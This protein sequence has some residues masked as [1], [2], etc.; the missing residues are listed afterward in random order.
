MAVFDPIEERLCLRVVYDGAAGAGKTT[1][2]RQ[3]AVLF[4]AQRRSQVISPA[5]IGDKTLF[6]DWLQ[7]SAGAVC[8][9]P[10]ICQVVSVPGQ[11]A[12]TARRRRLLAS[13]DVVVFVCDSRTAELERAR[14][15]LSVLDDLEGE[16]A[17]VLQANKQD[18]ADALAGGAVVAALGRPGAAV[19]E[20]IAT[21]GIGVID[22]FVSAVR[23]AARAIE[24]R[25]EKDGGLRLPVRRA[26]DER[27]LLHTLAAVPIDRY[28]A[29]EI[30]LEEAAATM[31]VGGGPVSVPD[32]GAARTIRPAAAPERE[33]AIV[34]PAAV[35]TE[36]AHPSAVESW[37]PAPL[38]PLPTPDVP[39]GFVWP[40][41]TGRQLLRSLALEGAAPV[42]PRGASA[43]TASH[44][45]STSLVERFDDPDLARQALVRA[46]RARTQLESLLV[47]DTVL[48]VQ[49]AP[50]GASWL[51]T[52]TPRIEPAAPW[53]TGD[54]RTRLVALA[55]EIVHAVRFGLRNGIAFASG[56]E[57]FGI[58]HGTLRY[59]GPL[60]VTDEPAR[61]AARLLS[62]ALRDA[63]GLGVDRGVL[64]DAL[65]REITAR[66][67][68]EDRDALAVACAP[69]DGVAED[70]RAILGVSEA[71]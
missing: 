11:A 62:G 51:W 36:E 46:A 3:L 38:A 66:V 14:G 48:V 32:V 5:T 42:G 41:H 18:H 10:L 39:T 64:V 56:L 19:V 63:S 34:A 16:R 12:F 57:G 54:P 68:A 50:D 2:V 1:N 4:A 33:E 52:V 47:A 35:A 49:P 25:S 31:L 22:T 65:A 30:L 71:A 29:A 7:I 17:L 60:V 55:G 67:G 59:A 20:A 28:G 61:A 21:E 8:G 26:E 9:L 13:A 37:A 15:A 43:A 58:Q 24:S 40:A 45:L 27:A 53:L 70:L 6:F 69:G 23:S 44:L